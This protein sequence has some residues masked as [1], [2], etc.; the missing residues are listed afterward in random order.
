MVA[1]KRLKIDILFKGENQLLLPASLTNICDRYL[2]A[3]TLNSGS[4]L[5]VK[6]AYFFVVSFAKGA[7]IYINLRLELAC[8]S[9]AKFRSHN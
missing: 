7:T 1:N 3:I 8:F 9:C 4:I 6:N 5:L 2:I